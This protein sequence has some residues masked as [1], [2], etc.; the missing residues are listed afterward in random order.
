VSDEVPEKMNFMVAS[1]MVEI[2]QN[3]AL[4]ED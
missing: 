3:E 4:N 2:H 1:D